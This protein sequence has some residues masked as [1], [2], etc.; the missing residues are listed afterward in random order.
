MNNNHYQLQQWWSNLSVFEKKLLLINLQAPSAA[1]IDNIQLKH[2][3][4]HS[5]DEQN[6]ASFLPLIQLEHLNL[7]YIGNTPPVHGINLALVLS[8][9][10]QLKSL[11]INDLS[12]MDFN[13]KFL[14]E[15]TSF[16]DLE[17]QS[18]RLSKLSEINHLATVEVLK[19]K[20]C[21]NLSNLKGIQNT[22]AEKFVFENC[23]KLSHLGDMQDIVILESISIIN[24]PEI[25]NLQG[26]N[27]YHTLEINIKGCPFFL[28]TFALI[29]AKK[30]IKL[31]IEDVEKLGQIDIFKFL[32]HLEYLHLG[33]CPNLEYLYG[34]GKCKKLVYLSLDNCPK[35]N[36]IQGL[37]KLK[38][39]N[40]SLKNFKDL[41]IFNNINKQHPLQR[42][43]LINCSSLNLSN[44]AFIKKV[45]LLIIK[46]CLYLEDFRTLNCYKQIYNIHIINCG[47]KNLKGLYQIENLVTL[48]IDNCPNLTKITAIK[49]IADL[50]LLNIN[51]CKQLESLKGVHKSP[52]LHNLFLSNC[53]KINILDE[54]PHLQKSR[55]LKPL[56]HIILTDFYY[57]SDDELAQLEAALP[58][59]NIALS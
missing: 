27:L 57:I 43:E 59:C 58:Q 30:L 33:N 34:L 24:C 19:F 38:L 16:V 39:E 18:E 26:L 47:I 8:P 45:M 42:V 51:H 14:D 2:I 28:D 20:N 3:K 13:M 25:N 48:H 49:H 32:K 31:S 37:N 7:N 40:L 4:I 53:E 35:L 5:L 9:F 10:S 21:P 22:G 1:P 46:D 36:D 55:K 50:S 17:I 29:A 12:L 23:P 56:S 11:V 52:K 41:S 54:I 15:I 44:T 6:I